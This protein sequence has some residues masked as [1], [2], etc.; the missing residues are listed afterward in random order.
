MNPGPG[1]LG[2]VTLDEEDIEAIAVRVADLLREAGPEVRRVR[3]LSASEV[4]TTLGVSRA[5]VY[6][7]AAALGGVRLVGSDGGRRTAL[8]FDLE[9]VKRSLE[10]SQA[11]KAHVGAN[12]PSGRRSVRAVPPAAELIEY[13]GAA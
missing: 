12:A 4:A 10:S 8:R 6:H 3:L 2:E 13:D 7:H 9:R 5:W 1:R 11:R